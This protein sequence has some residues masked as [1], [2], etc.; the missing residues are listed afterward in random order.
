VKNPQIISNFFAPGQ[1]QVS[2]IQAVYMLHLLSV[3]PNFL[4]LSKYSLFL[5]QNPFFPDIQD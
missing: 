2:L 1:W 4:I 3:F 5:V